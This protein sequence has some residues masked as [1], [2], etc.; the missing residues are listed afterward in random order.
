MDCLEF[1]RFYK[2]LIVAIGVSWNV[3]LDFP[4]GNLAWSGGG[5][6]IAVDGIK[7]EFFPSF[8]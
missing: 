8:R 7:S 3:E 6:G 2:F 4:S 1:Y 5:R